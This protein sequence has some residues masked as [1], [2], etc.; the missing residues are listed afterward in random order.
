MLKFA[1]IAEMVQIHTCVI[2]KGHT[3][4]VLCHVLY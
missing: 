2:Y 4:T 1:E 3:Y